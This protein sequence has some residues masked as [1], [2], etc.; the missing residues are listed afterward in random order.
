LINALLSDLCKKSAILKLPGLIKTLFFIQA[1]AFATGCARPGSP[2]GGPE[3]VTPPSVKSCVPPNHTVFFN[4]KKITISFDEFIQ[5]KDPAKEIFI[6]PPMRIRP[7]IKTNGKNITVELQEELRQNSTYTINFGNSV[8]DYTAGNVLANY[9]YVFSTGDHIDSLSIS[10]KVVNAFNGQPEADIVAMVYADDNDTIQFDSLP[11]RVPPA[12]ASKTAKD[13]SFRI[14]NLSEGKYKLVALQDLNNN[15]FFDL[16]NERFAFIDSLI[17]PSYSVPASV[18]ADTS[19]SDSIAIPLFSIPEQ[20]SYMLRIF[21][22]TNPVQRLVGKKLFGTNLLQYIFRLP[23]D[24]YEISL[25]NFQPA[26]PDWY[27]PEFNKTN[28][29]LNFWL[30]P[31]LPDTIRVRICAGDSLADTSRFYPGRALLEKPAKRKDAGKN[32]LKISSNISAGALDLNKSLNLVF[33]DPVTLINAGK[34]TLFA[35]ADTIV[36]VF[37]F[38]DSIRRK[39]EISYKW[40]QKEL[41][42]LLIADSA[43][44]DLKGS[45]NDTT[46]ISFKVRSV[47][48]YGNLL[49]EIKLPSGPGQYIVQLMDEKE[50]IWQQKIMKKPGVCRFEY[51]KPGNYKVKLIFDANSNG[52]WDTGNYR[53]NLLPEL[54]KYYALPLN[55]RANWDLQEEWNLQ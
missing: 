11:L 51:L 49:M 14:N 2:T 36:P 35:P 6:S 44:Y 53:K 16:P 1:V 32:N 13:G 20:N 19:E 39:G 38:A 40:Q 34:L 37:T 52:K 7:E 12:C 33:P 15:Y 10:G 29:T 41:Y 47:E 46:Y 30:R 8:I 31:G 48:D 25:L 5:L 42:K 55:I 17:S 28:D 3:D 54:V 21:E 27:I 22:E 23:V 24:Y 26:R 43:F 45:Y 9:E 4:E 50:N 18:S